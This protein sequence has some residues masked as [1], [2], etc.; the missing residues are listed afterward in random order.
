[1]AQHLNPLLSR[2]RILA[3]GRL[4]WEDITGEVEVEYVDWRTRWAI[5]GIHSYNWWWVR[6]WGDQDCGCTIN[7]ITRRRVLTSTTCPVNGWPFNLCDEC[8]D[9]SYDNWG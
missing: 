9:E 6:K 4:V 5:A 7:P 8:D 1:M 2:I 3:T